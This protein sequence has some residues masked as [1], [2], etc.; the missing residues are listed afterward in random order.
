[1]LVM[2][3][4]TSIPISEIDDRITALR[5]LPVLFLLDFMFHFGSVFRIKN[6]EYEIL[7]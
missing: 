1:M 5:F 7:R 3:V 6:L 4:H 2:I